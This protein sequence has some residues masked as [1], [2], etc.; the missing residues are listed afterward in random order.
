MSSCFTFDHYAKSRPRLIQVL[1]R[2]SKF[3]NRW[4]YW[5]I[6]FFNHICTAITLSHIRLSTKNY[7]LKVVPVVQAF[8]VIIRDGD[9][10][11]RYSSF[12][13]TDFTNEHY[14]NDAS[15]QCFISELLMKAE[16]NKDDSFAA[17]HEPPISF[18]N[19]LDWL[20]NHSWM[21][22]WRS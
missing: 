19:K 3:S 12:K 10:Q 2:T 20:F 15:N 17:T 22:S 11:L 14:Q 21:L 7:K 8:L 1:Q 6:S 13:C 16:E 4:R 9:K 5:K 18:Q